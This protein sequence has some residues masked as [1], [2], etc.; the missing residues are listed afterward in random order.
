MTARRRRQ[1]QEIGVAA[2]RDEVEAARSRSIRFMRFQSF[3][4][5]AAVAGALSLS[6]CLDQDQKFI[7]N[8]DGSGKMVTNMLL[9]VNPQQLAGA[10]ES[11]GQDLSR[12]FVIQLIRGTEGVEVWSE[13]SQEKTPDGK[14]K[15]K[16][17]AYFPDINK[18]KMST[19]GGRESG[20]GNPTLV[21]KMEGSDWIVGIGTPNTGAAPPP[22]GATKSP[23]EIKSAV[24]QAQQQWQA[25]K[26]FLAPMMQDAKMRTTLVIGGTVKSAVGFTKETENTALMQFNGPKVIEAIDKMV[27]DPKVVEEATARGG[28]MMSVLRDEKRMQKVIMESI[29]DGSGMP[30]VVAAPGAAAFDYK[31]EVEKAKAS[32]SP[33]V[34]ALLEEVKK[35]AGSVVRPPRVAPPGT[36]PKPPAPPPNKPN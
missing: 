16:A 32:Q 5:L 19:G 22:G 13:V 15:I 1:I 25:T 12:Q 24:Q 9:H 31:A 4:P 14:T 34:K 21:S 17:T 29:T 8:P 35:P 36:A 26:G 11:G 10:S 20:S 7:I 27:M 6:A 3:L 28:D 2:D 18:F 23:E 33:E 30:R